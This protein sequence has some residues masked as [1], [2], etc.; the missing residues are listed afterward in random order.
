MSVAI[1]EP[2]LLLQVFYLTASAAI[3]L[4]YLTPALNTRFLAYGARDTVEAPAG[5]EESSIISE[6]RSQPARMTALLDRITDIKVPHQWF[7][8]FYIASVLSSAFWA[9]QILTRGHLY[10]F[11]A[12]HTPDSDD[13]LPAIRAVSCWLLLSIQGLRR[14]SEC[15]TQP[16]GSSSMWIGHY[17]IGFAFYLATGLAIWI[18]ALPALKAFHQLGHGLDYS[19]TPYYQPPYK[20]P[21]QNKSALGFLDVF[22]M[23]AFAKASTS[24]N[25]SHRHL[26][27]LVKYTLPSSSPFQYIIA[28]HYTAECVIYLSLAVLSR[29]KGSSL[30]HTMAA[31]LVFV[32]INLGISA[33]GTKT[34]MRNKF[35]DSS[36]RKKWRMLPGVW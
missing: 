9:H 21:F 22:F 11:L 8:H 20:L 4:V 32:V 25:T 33:D 28:P 27:S 12:S 24:Q 31:A 15:L 10:T 26:A 36:V 29:P 30:N 2:R 34:W 7:I 6:P 14:L 35:G 3:L 5:K 17:L 16:R 18:E 1:I 13:P 19:P 23:L